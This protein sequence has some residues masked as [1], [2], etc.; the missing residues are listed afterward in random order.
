MKAPVSPSLWCPLFL[1]SSCFSPFSVSFALFFSPDAFTSRT[2]I[3]TCRIFHLNWSQYR[4]KV[5]CYYLYSIKQK[6]TCISCYYFQGIGF[7]LLKMFF[8][9]KKC[10]LT[11]FIHSKDGERKNGKQ[12]AVSNLPSNVTQE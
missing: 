12:E 10:S 9:Y 1:L 5:Y 7:S 3:S 6:K 11:Y 4:H 2:P 8:M